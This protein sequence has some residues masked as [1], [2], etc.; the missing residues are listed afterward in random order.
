MT[1]PHCEYTSERVTEFSCIKTID[2]KK[3]TVRGRICPQCN[4]SFPTFEIPE[5]EYFEKKKNYEHER[6]LRTT[7]KKET[8]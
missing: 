3:G 7:E 5:Q 4:R 6:V 1:C 8:T 2:Q